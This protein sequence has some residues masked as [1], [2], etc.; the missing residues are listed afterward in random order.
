MLTAPGIFF[1]SGAAVSLLV[2]LP[3]ARRHHSLLSPWTLVAAIFYM[4]C[5]L[6]GAAVSAGIETTGKS[7]SQFLLLGHGP[8]YFVAPNFM[9]LTATALMVAAYLWRPP[10]KHAETRRPQANITFH[11]PV[12]GLAIPLALVGAAAFAQ[13]VRMTG[14]L[15][16][17]S[18]SAKRTLISGV[19]LDQNYTSHGELLF[20]NNLS[21]IAFWIIVA[22]YVS[23]GRKISWG[24]KE[25]W[26]IALL[27][28]NAIALPF[29][30]SSRSDALLALLGGAGIALLLRPRAIPWKAI[31]LGGGA[32]LIL[33]STMTNLR[34]APA[35]SGAGLARVFVDGIAD[36]FVYS[37]N[38]SDPTVAAHIYH[39]VP[40]RI[41]YQDGGT[42]TAYALAPIPRAMWPEKPLVNI[43]PVIG[44]V[45]Y[46]YERNGVPAGGWGICT[47]TGVYR[48]S[49]L[50]ASSSAGCSRSSTGGVCDK[51][52]SLRPSQFST[53]RWR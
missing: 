34:G 12:V 15:N 23:S 41:P 22:H 31:L 21:T 16:W 49:S 9:Y 4:S 33:L 8:D 5:G 45:I 6:R 53:C 32:I 14:G 25:G 1:A 11:G 42:I 51:S 36:A 52:S 29:Y 27:A 13:Y 35:G 48:R 37:R 18:L 24:T 20:L 3:L 47:S 40:E 7:L 30:A 28:L 38:L 39:A 2:S 50:A 19:E 46:G 43:G 44:S 17:A 26:F 10:T